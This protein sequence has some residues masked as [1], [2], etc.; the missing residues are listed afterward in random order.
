MKSERGSRRCRVSSSSSSS[1]ST[2]FQEGDGRSVSRLFAHSLCQTP[3]YVCVCVC[4]CVCARA[5]VAVRV[6]LCPCS[7]VQVL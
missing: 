2:N 6:L 5:C 7:R 4:S 1:R 3:L